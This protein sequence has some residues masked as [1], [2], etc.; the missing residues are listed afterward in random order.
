MPLLV[1]AKV[2][3]HNHTFKSPD[4]KQV[5]FATVGLNNM[6]VKNALVIGLMKSYETRLK[7]FMDNNQF[8]GNLEIIEAIDGATLPEIPEGVPL[9]KGDMGCLLSHLKALEYAKEK[10]WDCVMIF[11]DDAVQVENFEKKLQTCMREMPG[12]WDM[13]WLG[14]GDWRFPQPFSANLKRLVASW[15]TYGYVIR[16]TVYDYFIELFKEQKRSSDDYFR[17]NHSK[18]FSFRTTEPLVKHA[19]GQSDRMVINH[20][21]RKVVIS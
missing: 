18:Y 2:C 15:G 19:V 4:L 12:N 8:K 16:D 10:G 17:L 20:N 14:G 5:D 7:P 21:T 6:P 9:S 1:N 3:Q 13:L 11:E